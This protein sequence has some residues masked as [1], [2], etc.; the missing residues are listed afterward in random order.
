MKGKDCNGEWTS[1]GYIL[2]KSGAMFLWFYKFYDKRA[3]A[4][5]TEEWKHLLYQSTKID[6]GLIAG[7]WYYLGLEDNDLY[8]GTWKFV[9][10]PLF[11]NLFAENVN[12]KLTSIT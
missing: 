4:G 2:A 3:Q 10:Q 11:I 7:K 8:C 6:S 1:Y 5:Q 9:A 12:T